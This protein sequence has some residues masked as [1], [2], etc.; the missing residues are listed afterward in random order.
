MAHDSI[1]DE[2]RDGSALF[3]RRLANIFSFFH[4]ATH[5]KSCSLSLQV[6]LAH[7]C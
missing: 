6:L 5:E 2:S 7:R 4:S 1:Q 3:F